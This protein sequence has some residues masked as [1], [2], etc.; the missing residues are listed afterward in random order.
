MESPFWNV[1]SSTER[2]EYFF[3]CW[4]SSALQLSN[5]TVSI[6][7]VH[8]ILCVTYFQ[9]NFEWSTI[10]KFLLLTSCPAP[11]TGRVWLLLSPAYRQLSQVIALRGRAVAPE[12]LLNVSLCWGVW[13]SL[14]ALISRSLWNNSISSLYHMNV[15]K[16]LFIDNNCVHTCC[17]LFQK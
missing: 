2:D 10:Q 5:N 6:K 17:A 1:H 7:Y 11:C 8:K 12:R 4:L 3:I 15:V 14:S 16:T 9:L 13:N